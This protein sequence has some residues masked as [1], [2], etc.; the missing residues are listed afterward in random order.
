MFSPWQLDRINIRSSSFVMNFFFFLSEGFCSFEEIY[1]FCDSVKYK[2]WTY[3]SIGSLFQT[4]CGGRQKG[5][6]NKILITTSRACTIHLLIMRE[7]W[8]PT[9]PTMQQKCWQSCQIFC[10]CSLEH[11]P[12]ELGFFPRPHINTLVFNQRWIITL[13]SHSY[14][15]NYRNPTH[16]FVITHILTMIYS[17]FNCRTSVIWLV[18][19]CSIHGS[20]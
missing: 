12:T 15:W 13:T 11:T 14:L 1:K 10:A 19:S 5:K 8:V 18:S 9:L 7:D 4:I 6:K 2:N 20:R 3:E 17:W 16:G